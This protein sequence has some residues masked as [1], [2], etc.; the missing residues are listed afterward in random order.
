V[1]QLTGQRILLGV[2]G[3]IAAYKAADLVRRLLD[4]GA[5]VQVVLTANAARFVGA[6]TFQALSG[7]PVRMSLWDEH[8]EAAMGHIELARWATTVLIAP[9]SANTIARLAHGLAD[10]LLATLVLASEAPLVIAPAMNRVMWANSA[11]QSNVA[12]L[13]ERGARILGPGSGDQACREVGDGRLLEPLEIVGALA[14]SGGQLAGRRVVVSA[15]PTYEDLDPVRFIGNRSSGRMGFAVAQAAA[16]AGAQVVL[17]AGPV[18]LP[19]PPNVRRVDVRSAQQMHDAVMA[20]A[21]DADIYVGAA[22]I[23]DYRPIAVAGDKIKK[24]AASLQLTLE[25]TP[26]ILAT[27]GSRARRPFLV[28]FAAETRDVE[29]YARDKLARKRL[30][31]IAANQVGEGKG[32]ETDDN[33]L[34]VLA[35]DG[36]RTP[37]ERADKRVLAR[38]LVDLI[39]TALPA[40]KDRAP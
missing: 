19:T 29:A 26:D 22:A 28:G 25:R 32:F 5:Q 3:G 39:A 37:L 7:E 40:S 17:V 4:A 12:R 1:A 15:G 14:S 38:L 9:A 11:T 21:A 23:A 30:D 2:C 27:L 18:S 16:D 24:S 20:E 8:A 6:P 10:D 33:A 36:S 35:A 31:L 13:R 34:V